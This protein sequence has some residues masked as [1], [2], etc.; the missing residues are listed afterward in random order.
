MNL[1]QLSTRKK[2][3]LGIAGVLVLGIA[4]NAMCDT[5]AEDVSVDTVVQSVTLFSL[6][7]GATSSVVASASGEIE[8]LAQVTLSSEVFGKVSRV[9]VKIGDTVSKGQTLVQFSSADKV[10]QLTQVQADYENTLAAKESLYKQIEASQANHQK[11]L[12]ASQNSVSTAQATLESAENA[13]RQTAETGSN[14]LV[15]NAYANAKNALNSIQDTLSKRLVTADNILGIDNVFANDDFEDVLSVTNI[16]ALNNARSSYLVAKTKR[17]AFVDALALVSTHTEI[18]GALTNAQTV[19][20]SYQTLYADLTR[21]LDATRPIGDLTQTELDALVA[22]VSAGRSEVTTQQT[23]L[24]SA[25]QTIATAKNS[26]TAQEIAFNKA[27]KDLA[28][29]KAKVAADITASEAGLAQLQ[30]TLASQDASI[31][32]AG[33]SVSAVRA[34]LAKT[35]VRSP[36]SGKVASIDVKE[37]ELVSSGS[38]IVEVV[39]TDGLQVVAFVPGSALSAIAIGGDVLVEGKPVGTVLRIAPSI[40]QAT[41]KVEVIVSIDK[42]ADSSFVVGQFVDLEILASADMEVDAPTL[43]PLQAV[44]V[45]ATSHDVLVVVDGHIV[46]VPVETG[47]LVGDRIEILT[48]LSAY[49]AIVAQVR[50][51][52]AGQEVTVTE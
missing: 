35:T 21:V 51:L 39:N 24:T 38:P 5:G 8:S 32:R 3:G 49:S 41:K 18:D 52:E 25:T 31:K 22:S 12:V 11:L 47:Q 17:Q 27:V 48:D 37:G 28:D 1:K 43:V 10:A 26:F 30:S 45:T 33:G 50:G 23:A 40:N 15:D 6:E 44:R 2:I 9:N 36:I 14:A 42:D 16:S 19:L 7:E 20:S 29:T 13:L 46:V 34:E 4:V